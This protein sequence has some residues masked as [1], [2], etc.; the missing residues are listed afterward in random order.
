MFES[1]LRTT[2]N[3]AQRWRLQSLARIAGFRRNLRNSVKQRNNIVVARFHP[4]LASQLSVPAV[5][6]SRYSSVPAAAAAG[7]ARHAEQSYSISARLF[8]HIEI[9]LVSPSR[10]VVPRKSGGDKNHFPLWLCLSFDQRGQTR[11]SPKN[12]ERRGSRHV[13]KRPVPISRDDCSL[14]NSPRVAPGR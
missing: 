14:A 12:H 5:G 3:F 8:S 9:L 11:C 4:L 7:S 6:V 13:G 2:D 10:I 1:E